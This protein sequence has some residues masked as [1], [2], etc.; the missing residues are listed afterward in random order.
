MRNASAVVHAQRKPKLL[1]V[2]IRLVV[3]L[4]LAVQMVHAHALTASVLL[5]AQRVLKLQAAVEKLLLLAAV[6]QTQLTAALMVALV[7]IAS[8]D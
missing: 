1:A 4:V 2:K 7:L 3:Q 5:H 6:E 8:A